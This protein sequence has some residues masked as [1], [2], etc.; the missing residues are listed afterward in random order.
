M[1]KR[2]LI[3]LDG[4]ELAEQILPYVKEQAKSFK[5]EVVL[6]HVTPEA[7][8]VPPGIPG[9]PGYPIQTGAMVKEMGEEMIKAQEYLDRI[10]L[11]FQDVGLKTKR[12]VLEGAAGESI[13][14]YAGEHKI[15]LIAIATHGRS[16]V[17]RAILGSVADFVIRESGLPVLMIRPKH[18]KSK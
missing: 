15:G 9:A 16:G 7:V 1:F 6:L 10:A 13:V 8:I 3:C 18:D 2:V 4:S 5:S 11:S 17:G 12:V 14:K